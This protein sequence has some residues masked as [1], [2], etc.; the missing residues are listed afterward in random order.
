M[1]TDKHTVWAKSLLAGLNRVREK[2]KKDRRATAE[3]WNCDSWGSIS[4]HRDAN[5][6]VDR[7]QVEYI[8]KRIAEFRGKKGKR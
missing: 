7:Q 5:E 8:A 4:G 3:Y 1:K 2:A 6:W